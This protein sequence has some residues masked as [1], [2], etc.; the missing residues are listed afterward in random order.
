MFLL[1]TEGG[2]AVFS[3]GSIAWIGGLAHEGGDPG[4]GRV[5]RNVLE[6]FRGPAPL[7]VRDGPYE[8]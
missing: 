1:A 3:V 5:T 4:V 2:G 7:P 8:W 6:R